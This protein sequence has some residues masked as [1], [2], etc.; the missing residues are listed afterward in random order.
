MRCWHGI[1]AGL[2]KGDL[3]GVFERHVLKIQSVLAYLREQ[4]LA[5]DLA[6]RGRAEQKV[7]ALLAESNARI[8]AVVPAGARAVKVYKRLPKEHYEEVEVPEGYKLKEG[9]RWL[10]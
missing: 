9:E 6:A 8:Q 2:R 5:F 10:T 3:W 1:F 4:G 7:S